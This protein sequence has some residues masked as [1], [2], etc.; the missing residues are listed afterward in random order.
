M[1]VAFVVYSVAIKKIEIDVLSERRMFGME[2][3]F[4]RTWTWSGHASEGI[5]YFNKD[6]IFYFVWLEIVAYL[7]NITDSTNTF[8]LIFIV[9]DRIVEV[10]PQRD[11]FLESRKYDLLTGHVICG[12]SSSIRLI[13]TTNDIDI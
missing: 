3:I 9:I 2:T 12:L 8:S 1:F 11:L 4:D 13:L 5:F 7:T 6:F 10:S